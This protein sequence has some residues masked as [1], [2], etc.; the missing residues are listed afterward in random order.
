MRLSRVHGSL[1]MSHEKRNKVLIVDRDEETLIAIERLLEDEGIETATTWSA[2][3]ALEFMLSDGYDLLVTGDNLPD[4]SCEQFLREIQRQGVTA[5]IVVMESA[6]S[7]SPV[8]DYF[9]SLGAAATVRKREFGKLL[10]C[11]KTLSASRMEK[12]ARAA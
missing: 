11:V 6:N 5:S 10:E 9:V 4:L 12:H 1:V 2:R 8:T 3:E 7:R